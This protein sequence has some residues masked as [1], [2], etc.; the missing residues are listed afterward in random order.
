MQG[1]HEEQ[2]QDEFTAVE[3][4]RVAEHNDLVEL[5]EQS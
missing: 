4:A 1:Q 3:L 2:D 5:L